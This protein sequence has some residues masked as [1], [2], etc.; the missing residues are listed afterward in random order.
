ML[1]QRFQTELKAAFGN[2]AGSMDILD[3][4]QELEIEIEQTRKDR[5]AKLKEVVEQCE[6]EKQQMK[7]DMA[8]VLQV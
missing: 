8:T 7:D 1:T 3:R 4:V 5:D 2:D 6:K